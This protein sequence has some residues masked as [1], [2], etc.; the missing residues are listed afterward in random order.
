[1]KQLL[2]GKLIFTIER[3]AASFTGEIKLHPVLNLAVKRISSHGVPSPPSYSRSR[4]SPWI[5]FSGTLPRTRR[6][7]IVVSSWRGAPPPSE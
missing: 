4:I 3:G 6:G 2:A 5:G 7:S 1:L